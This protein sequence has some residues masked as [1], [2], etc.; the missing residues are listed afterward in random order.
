MLHHCNDGLDQPR[1]AAL[2]SSHDCPRDISALRLLIA[3]REVLS[4]LICTGG[5]WG[6]HRRQRPYLIRFAG[7]FG[8]RLASIF[9]YKKTC[10]LIKIPD[11]SLFH[12]DV[13]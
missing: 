4:L 10:S 9:G 11:F 6:G 5:N 13:I 7:R 3:D 8:K 2:A 12:H 1:T